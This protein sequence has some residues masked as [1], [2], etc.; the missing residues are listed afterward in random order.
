MRS[1]IHLIVL[2][3]C[4]LLLAGCKKEHRCDTP[5]GDANCTI[6]I[7]AAVFSPLWDINGYA[8]VL[9]GNKG[10]IL[11]HPSSN[12]FKAFERTCPKDHDAAVV[13]REDSDGLILECPV[14]G[15]RFLSIDGTPL[16]GSATS[17][18]LL[19]YNTRFDGTA[20]LTIW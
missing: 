12:E 11:T 10:I 19:E 20:N 16:D 15:S 14:C 6:D 17:C 13:M 4:L 9:G 1:R 18:S 8:Y 3:C 2:G 5:F 7:S